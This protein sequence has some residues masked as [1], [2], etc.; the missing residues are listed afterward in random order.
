[1]FV[2]VIEISDIMANYYCL[3]VK[4]L[5]LLLIFCLCYLFLSFTDGFRLF[6]WNM[7]LFEWIR[8]LC[9]LFEIGKTNR[10][11]HLFACSVKY[12]DISWWTTTHL[13]SCFFYWKFLLRSDTNWRV[14][15]IHPSSK[16]WIWF[17]SSFSDIILHASRKLVEKYCWIFFCQL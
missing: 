2:L 4:R 8:F 13:V 17:L 11:C 14:L 5:R 1:M 9:N 12:A 16:S 15:W 7:T 3:R 6:L 10:G